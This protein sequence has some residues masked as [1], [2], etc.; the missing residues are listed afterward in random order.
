MIL[1]KFIRDNSGDNFG[2]TT[3]I[4]FWKLIAWALFSKKQSAYFDAPQNM[5]KNK[6][7]ALANFPTESWTRRKIFPLLKTKK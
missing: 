7:A 4:L 6:K 2:M 3:L 5:S 1:F